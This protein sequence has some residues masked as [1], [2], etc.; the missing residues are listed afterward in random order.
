MEFRKNEFFNTRDKKIVDAKIRENKIHSTGSRNLAE[1]KSPCGGS[2]PYLN[3]AIA[4][5]GDTTHQVMRLNPTSALVILAASFRIP[6]FNLQFHTKQK[7]LQKEFFFRGFFKN[8][9]FFKE[10]ILKRGL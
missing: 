1:I 9:L 2:I 6:E 10:V 3:K 8:Y 5:I 7:G 4:S